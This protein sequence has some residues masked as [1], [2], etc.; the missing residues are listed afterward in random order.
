MMLFQVTQLPEGFLR[1]VTRAEDMCLRLR[2]ML[3]VS[4]RRWRG[5]LC[6]STLAGSIQGSSSIEGFHV[7]VDGPLNARDTR[8]VMVRA[9]TDL[10]EIHADP[11]RSER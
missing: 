1:V 11:F 2:F 7:T 5:L 3:R 9:A 8:P 6:R 10:P 4:P